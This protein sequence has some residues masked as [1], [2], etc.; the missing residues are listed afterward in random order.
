MKKT[1]SWFSIPSI[2]DLE[3]TDETVRDSFKAISVRNQDA[4]HSRLLKQA[5]ALSR[6]ERARLKLLL[7][8]FEEG[9][10]QAVPNLVR[11]GR[12][13]SRTIKWGHA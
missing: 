7:R 6:F 4:W 2:T 5:T 8:E 1:T 9:G 11:L 12:W 3:N 10:T 13:V